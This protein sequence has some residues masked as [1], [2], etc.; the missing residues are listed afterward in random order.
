MLLSFK[1][2]YRERLPCSTFACELH[3]QVYERIFSLYVEYS[4]NSGRNWHPD[5]HNH[6]LQFPRPS[7]QE[8]LLRIIV[9]SIVAL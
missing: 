7:T 1:R 3:L 6:L 2:L 4:K 8:L 9:S 5:R